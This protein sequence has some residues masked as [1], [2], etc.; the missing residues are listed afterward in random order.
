MKCLAEGEISAT[1][2]PFISESRRQSPRKKAGQPRGEGYWKTSDLLNKT[3]EVVIE[4]PPIVEKDPAPEYVGV[5]P[6]VRRNAAIE[7]D[8]RTAER[9]NDSES[10]AK[11]P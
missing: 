11:P 3:I 6:R 5:P 2:K 4:K 8:S 10:K 9:G 1:A 7:L